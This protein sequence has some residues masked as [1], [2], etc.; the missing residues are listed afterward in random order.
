[1]SKGQITIIGAGAVGSTTAYALALR[2][3]ISKIVFVDT[4]EMRCM[5]EVLDLSDL[6]AFSR[7]TIISKGTFKEA[8]ESDIII[9]AAGKRQEI[10]QS[11][12]DLFQVNKKIIQEICQQLQKVSKETIVLVITNPVDPLTLLTQQLLPLDR[13][14]IFSTGTFLDTQRLKKFLG[15]LL[16]VSPESVN[17]NVLGEHGDSQLVHWS[18]VHIDGVPLSQFPQI[19]ETLKKEISE[20]TKHEAY[21]IISC[22]GA[23]FFGIATCISVVCESILFNQRKTFP[24]S[25]YIQELDIC[26]SVPVVLDSTG[27]SHF[28][29]VLLSSE[30]QSQF[31]QSAK[32]L[33][34]LR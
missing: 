25:C 10:G 29:P 11:R 2:G 1:M 4:D 26:M 3:V 13:K 5:G 18:T 31:L 28:L 6:L 27:I 34:G 22:K 33:Q 14:K 16:S 9:I 17:V 7:T 32:Q 20:K 15:R 30:E 8:C 21:E 23:T 24:L 12:M 19:T